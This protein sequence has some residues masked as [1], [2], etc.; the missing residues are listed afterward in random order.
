MKKIVIIGGGFAGLA[1]LSRLLKHKGPL[2]ITLID[3]KDTSD[4]LPLLPDCIGRGIEPG[5]LR[6]K[7]K[8]FCAGPDCEFIRAKVDA[9]DLEKKE[10]R[11]GGGALNYDCLIIAAGS[12]TNFYG[13][14]A[15][16][17][18]GF[19]L[20][21]ADDAEAITAALKRDSF[22]GCL[23]CG[24]G[25]TGIE[26]ATNLRR[27]WDRRKIN[28]KIVIVERAA[29]ILGPLPQWM[30]EYVN[31]NL[32]RLAIE[33]LT[34]TVVEKIE[35]DKIHLSGGRE[36]ENAMLIWAAGVKAP[37]FIQARLKVDRYLRVNENCFAA[38]DAANFYSGGIFLRMAVQFAIMQGRR[39]A[40]NALRS[41][42]AKP[43]RSYRP[44]D[45]GYVIPMANNRSCGVVLGVR[46]KGRL[47]TFLHYS[48]CLYRSYGIKNKSGILKGLI[49]GRRCT[50]P[51]D[52]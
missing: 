13:N 24:G 33:V 26:A 40:D 8:N 19:K 52:F 20:D 39:A 4:F 37:D 27:Y 23:V 45:L 30:R 10:V 7:I 46:V 1:A 50:Y 18:Y 51:T 31:A 48:M 38:G 35:A 32:K 15:A 49:G 28:K 3:A 21:N 47:A 29:S 44:I 17:R 41:I 43:L 12:E 34:G 36:F 25:Y 22:D 14:E 6:F 11:F 2:A 5:F 16:K 9:L 42:F